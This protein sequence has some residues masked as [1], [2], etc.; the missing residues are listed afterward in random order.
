ME[1][2][3]SG[4]FLLLSGFITNKLDYVNHWN[5]SNQTISNNDFVKFA[6]WTENL[7]VW[8]Q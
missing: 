1:M 8:K 3:L 4:S 5:K 2:K 6:S 7:I